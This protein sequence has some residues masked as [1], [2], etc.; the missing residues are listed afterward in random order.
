[1][2]LQYPAIALAVS[3]LMLAGI[4]AV[5]WQ[6]VHQ[7]ASGAERVEH[8]HRVLSAI[9]QVQRLVSDARRGEG[10]FLLTGDASRLQTVYTARLQLKDTL[11]SL[12]AFTSDNATQRKRVDQLRALTDADFASIDRTVALNRT[13]ENAAIAEYDSPATQSRYA[14]ITHLLDDARRDE[15]LLLDTRTGGVATRVRATLLI[16]GFGYALALGLG[17]AALLRVRREIVQRR[18]AEQEVE[19][20]NRELMTHVSALQ[21]RSQQLA[22]LGHIGELLQACQTREE[23]AELLSNSAPAMFKFARGGLFRVAPSRN[24][25]TPMASW[26][27]AAEPFAPADCWAIRRG[28]P[29]ESTSNVTCVHLARSTKEHAF[30]VPLVAQ[31]EMLG[32]LTL[33]WDGDHDPRELAR[34]AAEQIALALA[35]LELQQTLR[36][37]A[38]RDPLTSLFNRRYMEESLNRELHRAARSKT[39]L[40][41]MMFDLDRFKEYNDL[42]GHAAGDNLLR[43]LGQN[44]AHEV[45]VED[46][47]CRYGGDEFVVILPGAPPECATSRAELLMEKTKRLPTAAM[48]D[49]GTV[50][51]SVG[52]ASFPADAREPE[53]LLAAA[54]RALYGAK[55]AGRARVLRAS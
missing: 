5:S 11:S 38:I 9:D 21:T 31:G 46:I 55:R 17:I 28:A 42:F 47:A 32:V 19:R 43:D 15:Q 16:V 24:M 18:R 8:T 26:P 22:I 2:R 1:L 13:N 23:A 3:A 41:V 29:H 35:N 44:I 20:A 48:P 51:L 4:A 54:D 50:T 36:M 45:R 49:G 30:C 34:A 52:V 40:S 25:V 53:G 6:S 10:G 14:Q 37:H 39:P 12:T 27:D 7:L 33:E